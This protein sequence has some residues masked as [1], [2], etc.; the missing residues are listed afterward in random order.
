M[1]ERLL[2]NAL[3]SLSIALEEA[4]EETKRIVKS[5]L[6][7]DLEEYLKVKQE[8]YEKAERYEEQC[9]QSDDGFSRE[10]EEAMANADG[11]RWEVR[12][13]NELLEMFPPDKRYKITLTS[14]EHWVTE[15]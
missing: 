2:R 8:A 9:L 6:K 1:E 11:L 10:T 12:I 15:S 3:I 4:P 7:K 5:R 14:G 13:A